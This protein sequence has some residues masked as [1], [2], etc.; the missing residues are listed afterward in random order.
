[1][2][3]RICFR[4]D[5]VSKWSEIDSWIICASWRKLVLT[6]RHSNL[7]AK[8]MQT[9]NNAT[10][11][12]CDDVQSTHGS[13]LLPTSLWHSGCGEQ[14]LDSNKSSR[15]GKIYSEDDSYWVTIVDIYSK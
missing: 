11:K 4:E 2:T 14:S 13:S 12:D 7:S 8:E 15:N 9:P 6:T 3:D 1:M 5:G 10:R